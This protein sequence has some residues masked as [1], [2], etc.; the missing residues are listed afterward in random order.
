MF[1]QTLFFFTCKSPL[2]ILFM[3]FELNYAK[4][5][6]INLQIWLVFVVADSLSSLAS[7]HLV[8]QVKITIASFFFLLKRQFITWLIDYFVLGGYF[9]GID[10]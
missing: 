1:M 8:P 7:I 4:N 9:I 5:K 3:L 2:T 6:K 10:Y